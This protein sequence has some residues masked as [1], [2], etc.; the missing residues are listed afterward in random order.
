MMQYEIDIPDGWERIEYLCYP[1]DGSKAFKHD[2]GA[3]V[4]IIDMYRTGL[5]VVQF[6]VEDGESREERWVD[7]TDAVKFAKDW[8]ESFEPQ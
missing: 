6:E 3:N 1:I 4:H 5:Y 2:A 8:M 7:Y